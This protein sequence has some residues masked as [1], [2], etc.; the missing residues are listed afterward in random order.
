MGRQTTITYTD[1][2]TGKPM[3]PTEARSV[4]IVVDGWAYPIEISEATFTKHVQPLIKVSS[5]R[6]KAGA[7]VGYTAVPAARREVTSAS[8]TSTAETKTRNAAIRLWWQR[9]AGR[10]GL[11]REVTD[12]G[13]IPGDVVAAYVAHSDGATDITEREHGKSNGAPV[14]GRVAGRNASAEPVPEP[15][16]IRMPVAEVVEKAKRVGV[17]KRVPATKS[18]PAQR[19]KTVT[20][21]VRRGRATVAAA[22]GARARKRA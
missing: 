15:K 3:E 17:A 16:M 8:S 9:N 5:P 4:H 12:R 22:E 10:G 6:V 2:V 18:A 21:D 11:P 7:V 20:A 19:A 14:G 1:D 13:R